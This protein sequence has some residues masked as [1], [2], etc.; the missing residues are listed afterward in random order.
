MKINC[1]FCNYNNFG[2]QLNRLIFEKEIGYSTC[3][4]TYERSTIIGIGSIIEAIVKKPDDKRRQNKEHVYCFTSGFA[5]KQ[6][7][8]DLIDLNYD[9]SLLRPVTYLAIRGEKTKELLIKTGLMPPKVNPVLADGGLLASNLVSNTNMKKY[10]VG[11]VAHAQE[12]HNP[13]F[14]ELLKEIPN[15]TLIE[16]QQNPLVFLNKLSECETI[17]STA[18][19]PL[20]ASD[21]LRIP[22]LWIRL[23]EENSATQRFKF[24]D[25][26]SAFGIEKDPYDIYL[27]DKNIKQIILKKYDI[28]DDIILQKKQD[29]KNALD[30]LKNQLE[31]DLTN[32]K[33]KYYTNLIYMFII[34]YPHRLFVEYPT[35]LIKK[36]INLFHTE[37][38]K[39]K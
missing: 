36:T 23:N 39:K 6:Q 11:I 33:R 24:D 2:D 32:E 16:I 7:I 25:Y 31:S 37:R 1:Y 35:R 4:S 15:S 28:S 29:L 5:N 34:Y 8:T 22:N 26:Y 17:I 19:H 27:I 30:T 21:S 3:W 10:E 18:M 14:L 38:K 20:I 12:K 9:I 13:I